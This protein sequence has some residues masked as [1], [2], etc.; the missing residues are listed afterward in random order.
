[1]VRPAAHERLH[2][3]CESGKLL[4]SDLEELDD[5]Q[6]PRHLEQ[7]MLEFLVLVVELVETLLPPRQLQR[8][9]RGHCVVV[10]SKYTDWVGVL[11]WLVGGAVVVVGRGWLWLRVEGAVVVMCLWLRNVV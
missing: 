8:V 11:R 9:C 4:P 10:Q 7:D 1:M 2:F 6:A 3:L 5:A